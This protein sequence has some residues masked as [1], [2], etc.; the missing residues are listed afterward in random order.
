MMQETNTTNLWYGVSV[1]SEGKDREITYWWG[2]KKR[3]G[4]GRDRE[5]ASERESIQKSR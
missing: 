5:R 1:H 4:G 2:K 3:G